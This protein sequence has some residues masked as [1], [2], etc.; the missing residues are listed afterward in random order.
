MSPAQH[1]LWTFVFAAYII[2]IG[3]NAIIGIQIF[4][5]NGL[6]TAHNA[7]ATTEVD[8]DIAIFDAFNRAVDD[9]ADAILIFIILAFA[10]RFADL[11]RHDLTGHLRLDA[12]QLERRQDF[13]IRLANKGVFIGFQR[14]VEGE[15]GIFIFKRFIR[16]HGGDA[17]NRHFTRFRVN[18]DANVVIGPVT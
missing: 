18:V 7:F 1:D 12:T 11:M 9:L 17:R 16:Y 2:N 4:A 8:N 3:P 15:L 6:I 10:F 13:F 14:R 5:R